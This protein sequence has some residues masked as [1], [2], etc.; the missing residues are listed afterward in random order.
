[1][2]INEE[3]II[4]LS[5]EGYSNSQIAIIMNMN[6]KNLTK[7][8]FSKGIKCSRYDKLEITEEQ[9][10][11]ILGSILGDGYIGIDS[12]IAKA[13]RMAIKHSIKQKKYVEYKYSIL[14]NLCKKLTIDKR[15]DERFINPDYEMVSFRTMSHPIFTEYMNKFYKNR[16][17]RIHEEIFSISGLGLAIWFMDDGY[18]DHKTV[19]FAT[20]CFTIEDLETI[21][22]MFYTKFNIEITIQKKHT[23]RIRQNSTAKFVNIISPFLIESMYYKIPIQYRPK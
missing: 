20:N 14:E 12:K 19:K 22:K 15:R 13:A 1:M 7:Y 5:K 10:Q 16:K 17:K 23:I 11:V 4:Q 6:P 2:K 8:R 21:Q 3:K 18:L 9:R